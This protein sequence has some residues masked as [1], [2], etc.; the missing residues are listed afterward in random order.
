MPLHKGDKIKGAI[1][2]IHRDDRLFDGAIASS[3]RGDASSNFYTFFKNFERQSIKIKLPVCSQ[4]DAHTF[5]GARNFSGAQAW[6]DELTDDIRDRIQD[7]S[8]EDFVLSLPNAQGRTDYQPL[9]ALMERW[10]ETTHTFH[11]PFGELTLDPV[12]FAAVTGIACAGDAVPFDASI[13]LMTP[14]RVAYIE[15]LLGM[16]PD[17]KGTHT[18][19]LDSIRTYYTRARVQAATSDRAIDQVVRAFLVLLFNSPFVIFSIMKC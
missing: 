6:Y 4:H 7:T 17:M 10:F 14:D 15:R 16:V 1:I 13:H 8:F 18:I 12:S 19:K 5:K 11:L 9:H 2:S 3:P